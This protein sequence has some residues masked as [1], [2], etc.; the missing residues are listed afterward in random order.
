[1]SK[2]QSTLYIFGFPINIQPDGYIVTLRKH[3]EEIVT[4]TR[5]NQLGQID[6]RPL[7]TV[8]DFDK[9]ADEFIAEFELQNHNATK[10]NNPM[11]F[12]TNDDKDD[13]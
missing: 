6:Q 2:E 4:L 5:I 7:F 10:H 13:K 11:I 3:D 12:K 8:R 1:M 9:T